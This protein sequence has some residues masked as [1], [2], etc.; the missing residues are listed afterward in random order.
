VRG[1]GGGNSRPRKPLVSSPDADG[2]PTVSAPRL[3]ARARELRKD[4]TPAEEALW[5][6][7]RNR[8][9]L[10]LKFRRQVPLGPYIADFYCPRYQLVVELDGPS[11]DE[12]QQAAHDEDRALYLKALGVTILRFP[13]QRVFEEPDAVL[14]E[15]H[16]TVG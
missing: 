15:I 9:L 3:T 14:G 2:A 13:N 1:P 5:Q 4:Q 16:E 11:H 6:L 7:L 10:R 12:P 8:R